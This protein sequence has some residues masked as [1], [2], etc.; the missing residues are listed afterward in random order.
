M[1]NFNKKRNIWLEF[2]CKY[3]KLLKV[4]LDSCIGAKVY[5]FV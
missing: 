4:V 5:I 2:A 1:K 3:N